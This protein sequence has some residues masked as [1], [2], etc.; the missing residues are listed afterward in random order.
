METLVKRLVFPKLRSNLVEFF[1]SPYGFLYIKVIEEVIIQTLMTQAAT[2]T[3]GSDK[4]NFQIL[5]MI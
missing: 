3:F 2:K 1:V 5:W 4:I